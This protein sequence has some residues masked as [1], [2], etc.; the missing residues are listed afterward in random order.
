MENCINTN[1]ILINMRIIFNCAKHRPPLLL[2]ILYGVLVIFITESCSF[3]ATQ[4]DHLHHEKHM[5][6]NVV[7]RSDKNLTIKSSALKTIRSPTSSPIL[8]S[9]PTSSYSY[10]SPSS[11]FYSPSSSSSSFS[12]SSSSS[13]NLSSHHS[14]LYSINICG[15]CWCNKQ[16]QDPKNPKYTLTCQKENILTHFPVIPDPQYRAGITEITLENQRDLVRLRAKELSLYPSLT[17]LVISKTGLTTLEE[18]SFRGNPKL[19][20]IELKN[21]KIR[22]LPWE[23]F[24]KLLNSKTLSI[25]TVT[26]NPLACNCSNKWIQRRIADG[27]YVGP[28]WDKITCITRNGIEKNLQQVDIPGCDLPSVSIYPKRI[29][30]QENESVS[31]TCNVTGNP[32]SRVSWVIED[33]FKSVKRSLKRSNIERLEY[34]NTSIIVDATSGQLSIALQNPNTTNTLTI[35]NITGPDTGVIKCVGENIAGM[36]EDETI[37]IVNGKPRIDSLQTR[38]RFHFCIEYRIIG[39]PNSTREWFFNGEPLSGSDRITDLADPTSIKQ[40]HLMRGCLQI[41]KLV[42]SNLGNYTLVANN[43]YGRVE[44]TILIGHEVVDQLSGHLPMSGKPWDASSPSANG[45]LV[46]NPGQSNSGLSWSSRRIVLS[47][48]SLGAILLLSSIFFACFIYRQNSSFCYYRHRKKIGNVIA[49][50]EKIPLNSS[51]MIK[52]LKYSPIGHLVSESGLNLVE[53]ERIAFIKELGEGA[54]GRVFLGKVDNLVPDEE[55]TLVAIKTLKDSTELQLQQDFEREAE[56]LNNLQHQNIVHFFGVS[57]DGDTLMMITE[58][59]K[60]GDLNNYLRTRNPIISLIE[61]GEAEK[62]DSDKLYTNDLIKIAVQ[63]AAGLEYLASQHFVHRDLATRN[64]LVADN[65]LVKIGDFGL[66]RDLYSTDYYKIGRQ[67]MLPI[68]WMSPESILYRKFTVHSDI[69]SYGVLLWE[70]FTHGKQPFYE[71]SDQEVIRKIVD[72]KVL[73]K[74]DSCPDWIYDLMLACWNLNPLRRITASDMLKKLSDSECAE[75]D[76][77]SISI[78]EGIIK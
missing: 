8:P 14:T 39:V 75:K 61:I 5:S 28:Y 48:G 36:K 12:S 72:G 59:M 60:Y 37:I 32:A 13:Y 9:F 66:S 56:M 50:R 40:P 30:I 25:L 78:E 29:V 19:A 16:T 7:H 43:T 52:N 46:D 6:A 70:L 44:K 11:T 35:D 76:M 53:K 33:E 34:E 26:E 73:D 54:F 18:D 23:L 47:I 55:S 3:P 49:V 10:S 69:W 42:E 74:P 65:L 31:I 38:R 22:V 51:K 2:L 77:K 71:L 67:A 63:I 45:A 57:V 21:N 4:L 17:D 62:C 58:Y 41:E 24:Q 27:L 64:C 1:I 20:K 68:R 15:I